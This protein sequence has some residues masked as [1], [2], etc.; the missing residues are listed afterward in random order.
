[1]IV[2]DTNVVSELMRPEPDPQVATWVRDRG[3][4]ELGTTAITL[5]EVRYGIARLTDGR[6]KQILLATADEIFSTYHD[7]VLPFDAVAAEQYAIIAS[8]RERAGRPISGFDA[9]IAAVCRARGAAL[10]TRNVA[11]FEGTGVEIIDPWLRQP[12]ER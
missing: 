5:A 4:R 1:M 2:L 8:T 6:R 7:Q 9:Q 12:L 10:A 3:R 11:D